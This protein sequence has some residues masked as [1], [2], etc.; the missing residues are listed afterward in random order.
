MQDPNRQCA[1][2]G[3]E[4]L[5]SDL[6]QGR[7]VPQE[8]HSIRRC[9]Q[10]NIAT[11][12][13]AQIP[14]TV[15]DRHIA[16][17]IRGPEGYDLPFAQCRRDSDGV[18][19]VRRRAALGVEGQRRDAV[20][21]R[22]RARRNRGRGSVSRRRIHQDDLG[23]LVVGDLQEVRRRRGAARCGHDLV[24]KLAGD[25]P[26]LDDQ[27]RDV[28]RRRDVGDA[29]NAP[30]P[31]RLDDDMPLAL[32]RKIVEVHIKVK[33]A[34]LVGR[35]RLA[36]FEP[37]CRIAQA[38]LLLRR[39]GPEVARGQ[40]AHRALDGDQVATV[41]IGHDAV[42][43][44]KHVVQRK[45][46][47]RGQPLARQNE[48][49]SVAHDDVEILHHHVILA[50]EIVVPDRGGI[51]HVDGRRGG[52]GRHRVGRERGNRHL[53][54]GCCRRAHDADLARTGERPNG[55]EGARGERDRG[56]GNRRPPALDVGLEPDGGGLGAT[57]VAD[58][59]ARKNAL[60]DR[61]LVAAE[62]QRR[63]S[64]I[65]H[66]D[67]VEFEQVQDARDLERGPRRGARLAH[68]V[69]ARP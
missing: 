60:P 17:I 10:H 38:V 66:A 46:A 35:D 37:D 44:N 62:H 19:I 40:V 65:K 48:G 7:A 13:G 54:R 28:G 53:R 43:M 21:Q 33:P 30:R 41:A 67:V 4:G 52:E 36:R 39:I 25:R 14:R 22:H 63:T 11:T 24:D 31:H 12:E 64:D 68:N 3:R 51:G 23:F 45:P 16:Q 6:V 58:L 8:R 29:G 69:D 57:A 50:V 49:L 5:R 47:S 20:R 27:L 2:R 1:A 34:R 55:G 42:A 61:A 15:L 18:E 32:A 56:A 26:R 9:R 59:P